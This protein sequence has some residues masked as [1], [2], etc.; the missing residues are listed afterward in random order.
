MRVSGMG[1]GNNSY[2]TNNGQELKM[3]ILENLTRGW[4]GSIQGGI[5]SYEE[6]LN[7]LVANPARTV[8]NVFQSFHDMMLYFIGE[9]IDEYAGDPETVGYSRYDCHKLFVEGLDFPYCADRLFINKL[10]KI[11]EA[12]R[13][14][15]QNKIYIFHGPS[16]GGKS[17]F[18]NNLITKFGQYINSEEGRQFEAVWRL[19]VESLLKVSAPAPNNGFAGELLHEKSIGPHEAYVEVSCPS[20]DHPLLL[21]PKAYRRAFLHNHELGL[22][23]EF[24][25]KLDHEKE[26]DWVFKKEAC[27]ICTSLYAALL[28]RLGSHTEV[29]RMIYARPCTCDRRVGEI[30]SIWNPGDESPGEPKQSGFTNEKLQS[31]I[32]EILQDSKAVKYV[33][34]QY[35]GTNNGIYALMDIKG[36]NIDRLGGLHN[37]I[38]E[39]VYKVE[40]VEENID[41]LFMALLNPED[42][43]NIKNATSMADRT[44]EIN[45][46]YVRDDDAELEILY[47]IFGRANIEEHFLPG[48]AK[49]FAKIIVATRLSTETGIFKRWIDAP[50]K[51]Q[52]YC[53]AFFHLLKMEIYSGRIPDWLSEEDKKKFTA[54]IRRKVLEE[55]EKEGQRGFSGRDSIS[56]FSELLGQFAEE[57][58]FINMSDLVKYFTEI[59]K[60]AMR[61]QIPVGFLQSLTG[62]Y[63]YTVLNQVKEC[64]YFYNEEQISRDIQNYIF[65]ISF[66]IGVTEVCTYT[67]D[68]LEIT[69]VFLENIENRIW[70]AA[71]SKVQRWSF[72]QTAQNEYASITLTQEILSDGKAL[73]DTKLYKQLYAKYVRN[74][75]EKALDPFLANENFRRAIKDYGTAEFQVHDSRVK[76]EVK[77]LITNLCGEKY[78]YTEQGAKE[79]CVYVIDKNIAQKFARE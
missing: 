4:N 37:I 76:E 54:P 59:L 51:Y 60:D 33:Y 11:T 26:Y 3:I 78:G 15:Q 14:G 18:L 23:E 9:G 75:K 31:R 68:K 53:D 39:G 55:A 65:A 63:Q 17:V 73:T 34:S 1:V 6:F 79:I 64:L 67:G 56:M 62:L 74:I 48:I 44:V 40:G 43:K 20:H 27:T 30:T 41:S 42:K 50:S 49:N 22:S 38:S 35:A 52:L 12:L 66:D 71:I 16:G 72:R 36:R 28:Q 10:V 70:G 24:M 57:G 47:N 29:L 2:S 5:I 32:A 21:I 77:F 13:G 58:R 45:I 69:E 7:R 25:H 46:P 8:R 61:R 19:D